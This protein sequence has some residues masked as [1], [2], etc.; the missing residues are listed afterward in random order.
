MLWRWLLGQ[1]PIS[2]GEGFLFDF[3]LFPWDIAD[4]LDVAVELMKLHQPG[5]G[6]SRWIITWSTSIACFLVRREN[7][8]LLS[9]MRRLSNVVL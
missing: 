4:D 3:V 7:D 9:R 8:Y 5:V 1:R 2:E 6:T